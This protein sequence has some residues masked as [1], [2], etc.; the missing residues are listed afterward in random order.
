MP[1]R[2]THAQEQKTRPPYPTLMLRMTGLLSVLVLAAVG[3]HTTA[4]RGVTTGVP[5]PG[6]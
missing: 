5:C 3:I 2:V 6:S 4:Q 1:L